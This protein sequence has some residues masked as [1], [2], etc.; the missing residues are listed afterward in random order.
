MSKSD[1]FYF[2]TGHLS[3]VSGYKSWQ[4]YVTCM[5]SS[6]R[7]STSSIHGDISVIVAGSREKKHLVADKMACRH[8]PNNRTNGHMQLAMCTI[9]LV[10]IPWAVRTWRSDIDTLRVRRYI[11]DTKTD[12][13][14]FYCRHIGLCAAR[15]W[16]HLMIWNVG[17]QWLQIN[18]RATAVVWFWQVYTMSYRRW[19]GLVA[20]LSWRQCPGYIQPLCLFRMTAC[21]SNNRQISLSIRFMDTGPHHYDT[22][23]STLPTYYVFI[24]KT[25]VCMHADISKLWVWIRIRMILILRRFLFKSASISS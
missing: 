25:I 22:V 13:L 16:R 15:R 3:R 17:L 19:I 9:R 12:A 18:C 21:L 24:N 1:E 23:S 7:G 4:N 2:H 5:T 8:A 14:D 10:S 6:K 20:L 11:N